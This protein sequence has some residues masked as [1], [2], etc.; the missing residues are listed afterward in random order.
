[1]TAFWRR[2]ALRIMP[3]PV[4]RT[5]P[6]ATPEIPGSSS[7]AEAGIPLTAEQAAAALR[8][9]DNLR[10]SE[11]IVAWLEYDPVTAINQLWCLQEQMPVRVS[12]PGFSVRSSVNGYGGGAFCL[13]GIRAFAVDGASQQIH[14][15]ECPKGRQRQVT[16]D[17]ESRFG[18]LFWDPVFRRILAV[19]ELLDG[20]QVLAQQLVSVEP[21]DGSLAVVAEGA[22][23]YGT[24]AL[25]EDGRLLAWVTWSLPDMPWQ[26][27]QLWVASLDADGRA[28]PPQLLPTP[29]EASVQQP[30]FAANQLF[31]LSDHDGWWQPWGIDLGRRAAVWS[32]LS[33]RQADHASAPWQLQEHHS[34]A[35]PAG[36]WVRAH[37]RDGS[38]QLWWEPEDQP[39]QRLGPSYVDFRSLQQRDGRVFCVGRQS[40]ALDSIL[41]IDPAR[42]SVR[43][44]AGGEKPLMAG[45]CTGP[46]LIEFEAADGT[47][48][49][50]FFYPSA[51]AAPRTE[52]PPLIVRVHGGPTSAA[53]PVFDP[54]TQYWCSHGFAV[55]DINYR[56]STGFGRAFRLALKGR[57][58]EADVSDV[59]SAVDYLDQQGLADGRRAF[60]QGRS[61]G[62]YTA[63]MALVDREVFRAGASLFGVSDPLRLRAQTHRFESGY[64]DWLLGDPAEFPDRWAARTPVL[65]AHRIQAPVCFY[66]GGQDRVVVPAQ[67]ES[68]VNAL[69]ASGHSPG[70]YLFPEEGHGFRQ[71]HRQ[72]LLLSTL[73]EFYR[74][75]SGI[76]PAREEGLNQTSESERAAPDFGHGA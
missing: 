7:A 42:G 15:I 60:I 63:L 24:P 21:A 3:P 73:L 69:E 50:G 26:R 58:G 52:R 14:E 25:S 6:I 62:G 48:I 33:N 66:Q 20:D 13:A 10:V 38:G 76:L 28:S 43:V 41:E 51:G 23:F 61:A 67:T 46:E 36:G 74:R 27:S 2:G 47:G 8:Q 34:V 68:M 19:R 65:Q 64:L 22:D 17:P 75:H 71:A 30:G 45:G 59:C 12:A 54:Q 18:G 37:Y 1:M 4:W 16:C 72:A 56:G 55:A 44:L 35:L 49:T 9:R 31:A 70:Y 32:K 5:S 40:D 57:W 53:Y 39:R 11:D 29:T